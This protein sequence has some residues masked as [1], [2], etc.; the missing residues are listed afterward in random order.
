MDLGIREHRAWVIGGSSGLGLAI[1]ERLVAEGASV[2]ISSRHQGTLRAAAF[3][4]GGHGIQLD[5]SDG[6][7]VIAGK[8][9]KVA[10]LLGGL[11]IVVFN[12]GRPP[13]GG[14]ADISTAAF[15]AGFRVM[16]AGAFNVTKAVLGDLQRSS[17]GVIAYVTSSS[18]KE[19]LPNLLLSNVMRLGVVGLMKTVASEFGPHGIRALCVAPGRFATDAVLKRTGGA[20]E[21][22]TIPLGRLGDP[23]E[24][25]DLVAYLCSPRAAYLSGCSIVADG[26]HLRTV[27][28]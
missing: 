17:T 14:V 9:R 16:L 18:T 24:L 2:V 7:D 25:A 26:A 22:H 10:S 8:A 20:S 3:K 4:V 1:A 28:A 21:D 11:D 13:D 19:I 5:L 23:A 15:E 27:S 12:H 6:P